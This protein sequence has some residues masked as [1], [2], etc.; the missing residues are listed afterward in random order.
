[1]AVEDPTVP[2]GVKLVIEDYP[3]AADGLLIWAAIKELV[4]SYVE[5]YYSEPNSIS[6]DV[7]LQAWWNEIKNKGHHD[8]RKEPWWPNLST[9]DDLSDILTTMIWIASGQHAAINFGQYPLE[10]IHQTVLLSCGN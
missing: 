5:H 1:M 4:E 8:K 7:E 6:S 10:G 2:G 9:Q 3:Y